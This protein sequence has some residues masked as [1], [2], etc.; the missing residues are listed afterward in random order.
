MWNCCPFSL[1]L[2]HCNNVD[3]IY[4]YFYMR[5]RHKMVIYYPL[6]PLAP[7]P[8]IPLVV[9]FNQLSGAEHAW[10]LAEILFCFFQ[11]FLLILNVVQWFFIWNQEKT[12]EKQCYI[13]YA[14]KEGLLHLRQAAPNWEFQNH[15]EATELTSILVH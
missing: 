7:L 9:Y 2:S 11:P 6:P 4:C 15:F 5:W 10:K 8:S 14:L 3:M 1:F 12:S 13:L